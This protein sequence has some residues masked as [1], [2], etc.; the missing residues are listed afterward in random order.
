MSDH[1]LVF[2][3]GT[4]GDSH[5]YDTDGLAW[6]WRGDIVADMD[7]TD[8]R[9]LAMSDDWQD[10]VRAEHL[11]SRLR[12]VLPPGFPCIVE[13]FESPNLNRDPRSARVYQPAEHVW[14][15][16]PD[17][18]MLTELLPEYQA[19]WDD[20]TQVMHPHWGEDSRRVFAVNHVD[21]VKANGVYRVGTHADDVL[22]C[23]ANLHGMRLPQ[24]LGGRQGV[25]R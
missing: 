25:A 13:V 16:S 3:P 9:A 6:Y 22:R 8:L 14:V 19:M 5:R 23:T 15:K 4:A 1:S 7:V 17:L 2:D 18:G 24:R 11:R 12:F 21:G 20:Y 10:R